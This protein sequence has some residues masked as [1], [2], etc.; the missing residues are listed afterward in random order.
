MQFFYSLSP[1]TPSAPPFSLLHPLLVQ[2]H[3]MPPRTWHERQVLC[4]ARLMLASSNPNWILYRPNARRPFESNSLD[5]VGNICKSRISV[6]S[7]SRV[8]TKLYIINSRV[9]NSRRLLLRSFFYNSKN[10]NCIGGVVFF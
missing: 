1:L 3:L 10:L 5:F 8:F 7:A 2:P 6:I 9:N 4:S